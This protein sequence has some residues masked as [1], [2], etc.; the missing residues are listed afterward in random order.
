[1]DQALAQRIQPRGAGLDLG[2][3][4]GQ[5]VYIGLDVIP[6]R[7]QAFPLELEL[8]FPGGNEHGGVRV[9][10]TRRETGHDQDTEE[11]GDAGTGHEPLVPALQLQI[12]AA[13]AVARQQDDVHLHPVLR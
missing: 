12:M 6:G 1:V 9:A 11:T 8:V 3:P 5:R 7:S 4:D 13:R 2:E 10:H